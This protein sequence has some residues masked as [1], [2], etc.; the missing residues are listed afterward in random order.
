MKPPVQIRPSSLADYLDMM[1]RAIFSAGMH[2]NVIDAK[3]P[4][5]QEAFHAFDAEKVAALTPPDID[6]LM[7]DPRVIHNRKKLEAVV[8]NAAELILVDREFGGFAKYLESFDD[9]EALV[10]DLH[11]RF[12]FVG[13]SVARMFLYSVSFRPAEQETWAREHYDAMHGAR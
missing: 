13:E 1:A 11:K 9:T 3:W 6:R 2:R 7:Q 5:T 4:G 12:A 10:L 8:R